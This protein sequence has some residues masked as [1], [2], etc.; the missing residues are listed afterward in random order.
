[1]TNSQCEGANFFVSPHGA[2]GYGESKA[3]NVPL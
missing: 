1:M 2:L 3:S